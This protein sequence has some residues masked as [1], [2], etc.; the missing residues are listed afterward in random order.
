MPC[1][2]IL[3]HVYN[4]LR[5]GFEENYLSRRGLYYLELNLGNDINLY[6]VGCSSFLKFRLQMRFSF[7]L[8]R[9]LIPRATTRRQFP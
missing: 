7:S 3:L 1:K 5:A 8:I 6:W 9:I 4:Y 2:K